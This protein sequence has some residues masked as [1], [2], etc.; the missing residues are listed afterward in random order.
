[1][2]RRHNCLF[3]VDTVASLGA[4]PIFMDEQ[5]R[6]I[7]NQ[8]VF[9][10]PVQARNYFVL[11]VWRNRHPVHWF[12]EGSECTSRHSTH[13]FQWQSMVREVSALNSDNS[14]KLLKAQIPSVSHTVTRC[15]TGKQNQC[16]T[17]LIWLTCPIT[18]AVTGNQSERES[19]DCF[20]YLWQLNICCCAG[21]S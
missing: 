18:G 5:S 15:S 14:V 20:N 4:A 12:S 7:T 10:A 11:C 19:S 21:N 9:S 8:L 16:H 17:S 3:L 13:L 1:M 6:V 2:S